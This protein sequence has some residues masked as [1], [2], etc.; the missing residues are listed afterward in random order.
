MEKCM[1]RG[2]GDSMDTCAAKSKFTCKIFHKTEL[3][4]WDYK[5]LK[6]AWKMIT[7]G[8]LEH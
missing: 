6:K 8:H 4:F 7:S 3:G 1:K 2:I 5:F